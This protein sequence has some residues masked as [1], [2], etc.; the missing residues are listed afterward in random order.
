MRSPRLEQMFAPRMLL[1]MK[2]FF[3]L[4]L[5]QLI[6]EMGREKKNIP[7]PNLSPTILQNKVPIICVWTVVVKNKCWWSADVYNRIQV[8]LHI[9]TLYDHIIKER[10]YC[11]DWCASWFQVANGGL[12]DS[13]NSRPSLWQ[14]GELVAVFSEARVWQIV[15]ERLLNHIICNDTVFQRELRST[16]FS[17]H[18]KYT[19]ICHDRDIPLYNVETV[20]SCT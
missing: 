1:P 3:I 11:L 6:S 16:L 18:N 10:H 17:K 15:S 9:K 5:F 13:Y 19:G 14:A 8:L 2:T 4:S 7:L 12:M 20:I